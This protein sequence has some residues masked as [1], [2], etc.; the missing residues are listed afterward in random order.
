[1]KTSTERLEPTKVKLTVEVEAERVSAAIDAAAREVA[2]QVQIPGFRKG[3]VPRK[4]LES[5]VGKDALV[6]QALEGAISTYYAE[7]VE[8]EELQVVAPP[9]IDLERFDEDEGCAFAATVE[10]RPE[11][12]LPPHEGIDVTFPEWDVSGDEIQ[13]QIDE[14]RERFA[15]LEVV[16]REAK[17]GDYVTIDLAVAKDGEP[18]EAATAEDALY[19]VGSGGVTPQLDEEL[20]GAVAGQTLTYTDEL[21]EAYPVHGGEE[22]EFTVTVHDVR[23]KQLPELDDDFALTASEFDTIDELE[24]DIRRSIARRKLDHA[25]QQLRARI[26]EA[27]LALVDVP[28]PEVMVESEREGRME[29]LENQ[30]EQYGLELAELLEMQGSDLEEMTGQ[31][32][33]QAVQSVKAQLVLEALAEELE[34]TVDSEDLSQEVQR[35]AMRHGTD[36]RELANLINEQ[37]AVGVLVGDVARRKALD[38]LVDAAD[39]TGAPTDDELTEYGLGEPA[40]RTQ[41]PDDDEVPDAGEVP[42]ADEESQPAPTEPGRPE[43]GDEETPAAQGD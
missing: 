34:L 39:V 32:S 3:K 22:V 7:A 30:A 36:P 24:A 41:T 37:G 6:Q 28:L 33:Q 21:P 27:Y 35:H 18:V 13:D 29:Q 26:L 2:Q 15:E 23:A 20:A 42:E 14:L 25:R 8:N 1:M 38:A 9:E 17:I 16:D 4:L 10:V 31:L 40:E 12:D 11:F 43:L 19:E 5:R